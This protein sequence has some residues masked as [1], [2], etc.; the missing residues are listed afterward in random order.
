M[1]SHRILIADDQDSVRRLISVVL[2]KE[3]YRTVCVADGAQAIDAFRAEAFDL[4]LLD[5]RMPGVDGLEALRRMKEMRAE[6]PM[7]LMTAYAGVETAVD[8][9]KLG[10]FD[11]IVKPFDVEDLKQLIG[12][13]LELSTLSRAAPALHCIEL[14]NSND[15][16]E[17]ILTDCPNMMEVCRNIAKVSQTNATVLIVGESGTGKEL[18]AKAIH[19]HSKRAT[20]PFI[21]VNCGALPE[22]LLESTLFGHE[23]G[24]FTGAQSS[25]PGLFWRANH[26]TLLLDEVGEMSP[27]LQVKFLRVLQEKEFEPIGGLHPIKTDFRLIA[28]TNR[29]LQDM[30]EAGTFRQ[31]LFYRLNVMTLNPPPLR[32]RPADIV[33]LAR[34]FMQ[35]FCAENDKKIIDFSPE[36][37]AAM[38]V[39]PW[40]GNIRELSNAVERAVILAAGAFIG[41]EDLPA[42][43]GRPDGDD[44]FP[45]LRAGESSLKECVK[46]FERELIESTLRQHNG[47]RE[48]TAKALGVSK[49]TLL[50]KLQEHDLQGTRES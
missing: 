12:K 20:G 8:A 35:R 13:A 45:T 28:A 10:A 22:S 21:K 50:Y 41:V 26:G 49:R 27:A 43:I 1:P 25:Q 42:Q 7:I 18:V 3:G 34:H 33:L 15:R 36:A 32:E 40:P 9:L 47:H 11:Y 46:N 2:E 38:N 24:A 6:V 29:D 31:D 19:Y 39:Y 16:H 30:V 5:I 37:I 4:V 48:L 44:A 17:R 14:P 23:K